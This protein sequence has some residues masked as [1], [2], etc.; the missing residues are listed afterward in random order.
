MNFLTKEYRDF[1]V[2][3]KLLSKTDYHQISQLCGR[4]RSHIKNVVEN[5]FTTDEQTYNVVTDFY[6]K[7][8]EQIKKQ[9]ALING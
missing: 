5:G 1:L 3:T 7:K 9:K 6:L 4:T 8:A 2:Q